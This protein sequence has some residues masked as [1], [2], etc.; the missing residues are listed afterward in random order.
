M[1]CVAVEATKSL[2][3]DENQCCT[4]PVILQSDT[5]LALNQGCGAGAGAKAFFCQVRAGVRPTAPAPT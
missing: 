1:R 5:D 3:T 4:N 2:L